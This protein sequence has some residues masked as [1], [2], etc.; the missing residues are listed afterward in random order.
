M[1]W[2]RP[3]D[4]GLGHKSGLGVN[5]A[6]AAA[7]AAPPQNGDEISARR[8]YGI[9]AFGGREQKVGEIKG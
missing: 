4:G 9:S 7:A 8:R 5:G 2:G 1:V 3:N 6:P